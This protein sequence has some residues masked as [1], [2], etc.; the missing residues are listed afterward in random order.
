MKYSIGEEF[1]ETQH[2]FLAKHCIFF[3]DEEENKLAYM[4]IF[5]DYVCIV[6]D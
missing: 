2:N 1:V 5:H 3:E 4:D 6:C